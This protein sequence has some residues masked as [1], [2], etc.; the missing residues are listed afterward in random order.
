MSNEPAN[1]VLKSLT[2][3]RQ[4]LGALRTHFRH[5][6]ETLPATH[7]VLHDTFDG[8]LHRDG[9]TLAT[10]PLA[11]GGCSASWH[12]HD[13]T[14]RHCTG[15]V[16]QPTFAGGFPEGAMREAIRPVIDMRRLL[17]LVEVKLQGNVLRILDDAEKTVARVEVVHGV[18][19]EPGAKGAGAEIRPALSVHAVR[20]YSREQREVTRFLEQELG[21]ARSDSPLV[22]RALA[23]VGKKPGASTSK[24]LPAFDP[25]MP[26]GTAVRL[27]LSALSRTIR[28][29]EEGTRLDLDSEFLHDFRVAVRRTRTGIAQLREVFPEHSLDRFRED[30]GWLGSVTG[31]TRDLDVFLLN[32]PSYREQLPEPVRP[33]LEPLEAF[34][35]ARQQVEQRKMAGHLESPRYRRLIADWAALLDDTS[36]ERPSI[37]DAPVRSLAS[38]R[39][40]NRLARVLRRGRAIGPASPIEK[41]HRLRI[42]CKKLRYLLEF[43][44]SL[45]DPADLEPAVRGLKRL[46]DNLGDLNDYEVQQG[47]LSGFAGEMA[48]QAGS[49][50]VGLLA[51]GRLVERLEAKKRRERRRFKKC[52]GE[53]ASEPNLARLRRMLQVAAPE[54]S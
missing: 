12:S 10:R 40:A 37:A 22:T 24:I 8:R 43:F 44:R 15:M 28:L 4:I 34:L 52:F 1:Y 35:H 5:R 50:V 3:G 19:C 45:Y 51:V 16:E 7:A 6:A 36:G 38:K 53:F 46:Q 30:F 17:P 23:A 11:G 26:A 9:G 27:L 31:P 47:A 49:S 14:L 21:V 25:E 48:G 18:A 32:M 13:G 20:G 39:I 41:L 54:E 33:D 2:A 42:E 29:N